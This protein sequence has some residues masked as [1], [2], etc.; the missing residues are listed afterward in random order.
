MTSWYVRTASRTAGPLA[1]LLLVIP[2]DVPT[3]ARQA[4]R[5]EVNSP[6]GRVRFTLSARDGRFSY[7]VAFKGRSVIEAS[8]LGIAVDG[9][10]LSQGATIGAVESQKA[11]ETYPWYGVHAVATNRFN[12]ARIAARH[13]ES[14]TTYT[15]EVRAFNDGIGFRFIVPG[16]DAQSRV[17]DAAT[18]FRV[19]DGSVVWVADLNR[20]HYE[21]VQTRKLAT[22]V[23]AGEWAAPPMTVKLPGGLGYAS[24][25]EAALTGYP[26]MAL[27]GD[28]HRGF[29]LRLGHSVPA[30]YPFSLRYKDD[31]ERMAKAASIEGTITTPW[32]VVMVGADLNALV[33]SDIVHNL[34]APPDPRLFPE[35]IKTEW[36][37]PGRAV[38]KYLD[39]GGENTLEEMKNFSRLASELGFEYNLVEG[40]WQK[41]TPDQLRELVEYSRQ[42]NVGIWLWKHSRDLR[43]P[44]ARAA[45]FKVCR[46]A[47]A[48]GIKVDFFD[49]EAK[50][51]ID[52]Y[53][54]ILRGAAES[55]LLVNFHGANKPTGQ[56]RTW[57]NELTREAIFGLE[58]RRAETRAQ[59]E[60]TVPFTRFL[61]GA[62][63]Y[64]PVIFSERKKDT[65]WAHQI[66][67]AAVFSSPLMVYGAHPSSLLQNPAVDV[68]KSIPSVWDETI[69]LPMSEIGEVAA[70]ARRRGTQWFVAISNGP[71]AKTLRIPLDFLSDGPYRATLVRDKPDTADGVTVETGEF[72]RGQSLDVVMNAGG[73]FIGRFLR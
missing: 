67:T 33:N 31:V 43:D 73:G 54:A 10:N 46:D 37:K 3:A 11:D 30:S 69:V 52:R 13:G 5:T 29:N 45:F 40:F 55:H 70:F 15:I 41:W 58:Y 65:T 66:A 14:G 16:R 47:G 1:A 17:P 4:N 57:P 64:T 36:I 68:I 18:S 72:T 2:L 34:A 38:W 28:G 7:E 44:E 39:G 35:G 24:I 71:A 22:D 61:A 23:A 21:E 25:T 60:A 63:D 59:H 12:G 49:H 27:E 9:T 42:R 48:V 51:V 32:R 20:G 8:P 26:G 19:P 62:A 56:E 6:D 53:D 50:E